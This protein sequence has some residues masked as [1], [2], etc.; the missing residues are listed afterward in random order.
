[1]Q[2]KELQKIVLWRREKL[3]GV[4]V[5]NMYRCVV[6]DDCY[7]RGLPSLSLRLGAAAVVLMMGITDH[8]VIEGKTNTKTQL[9]LYIRRSVVYFLCFFQWLRP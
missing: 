3:E 7:L 4:F 1:M 6:T 8:L 5:F 2:Q 9:A